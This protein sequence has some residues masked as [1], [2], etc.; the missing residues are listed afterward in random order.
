MDGKTK[1]H[2]A[3]RG[4]VFQCS[5]SNEFAYGPSQDGL[6]LKVLPFV[7]VYR[8]SFPKIIFGKFTPGNLGK[9]VFFISAEPPIL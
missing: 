8:G 2:P 1:K 3:P 6:H 7:L 9:C 4:W 5:T